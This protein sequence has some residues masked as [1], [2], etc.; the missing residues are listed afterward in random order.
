MT[1]ALTPQPSVP[2][3]MEPLLGWRYWLVEPVPQRRSRYHL[4]SA[5]NMESWLPN[6]PLQAVHHVY[7]SSTPTIVEYARESSCGGQPPC[8]MHVP[9]ALPGCGIYAMRDP[10]PVLR[11]SGS[12]VAWGRV[13]LWGRYALHRYGM[14]AQ[15][16]YPER[17]VEVMA[18]GVPQYD[19]ARERFTPRYDTDM[20]DFVGNMLSYLYGVPYDKENAEW[21]L[22]QKNGAELQNRYAVL[23]PVMNPYPISN[24]GQ[25]TQNRLNPSTSIMV[26]PSSS[27]SPPSIVTNSTIVMTATRDNTR[28]IFDAIDQLFGTKKAP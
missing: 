3:L 18:P 9:G 14:R 5:F 19:V 15:Y 7:N 2:D 10:P 27:P 23:S 24:R 13:S 22:A 11:L 8:C 20:E 21:K 17:I 16:A 1:D 25:W 12:L 28:A 6:Q 26:F 4:M